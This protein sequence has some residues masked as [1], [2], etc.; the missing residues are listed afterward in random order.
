MNQQLRAI[1]RLDRM[2]HEPGRMMIVALLAA[3]DECDFR[4]LIRETELNKGNLSSHLA[5][6]EEAGYVEIEKTY[7]GKVPQTLLRLTRSGRAAFDAYRK[8][9]NAALVEQLQAL[10]KTSKPPSS[11]LNGPAALLGDAGLEPS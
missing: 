2:I 9:L 8:E 10:P 5:K 4:Y 1:A 7:R 6:L 3:V 11:L